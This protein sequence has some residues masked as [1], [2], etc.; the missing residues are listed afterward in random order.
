MHIRISSDST[1]DLSPQLIQENGIFVKPLIVNMGDRSF[2]DGIDITPEMI[3]A[4]VAAGN[5]LCTTSA[6]PV[7]EYEEYFAELK[8][9]CDAVIHI[10]LGSGFSSC[11]QNACIAAQ[12]IPGVYVVDS[13][14]LSTGQGHVVLEAC[15][16][17]RTERDPQ[18]LC[19]K[20]NDFAS[21][22]DASFLLDR[23]DYMVKGGRCSMVKALGANLL[24]LK[25]CIE[26]VDNKMVIGK[27][28]RGSYSKSIEN[29]VRERLENTEN[30]EKLEIFVTHTKVE[31]EIVEIVKR[32]VDE[33]CD[34]AHVYETTAGGTVTCH[35]GEGTLGV[36]YVRKP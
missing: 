23:L 17:A 26:V 33:C 6:I 12:E 27:K 32:T 29:Y 11:Y 13:R 16:L 2:C 15:R 18:E 7:G 14:N 36:L 3:Y 31:P 19:R 22:V 9:D 10:N 24:R 4:H 25:P 35:C 5:P 20:L 8:K 28:Y 21:R 1:C 30:I 34:F